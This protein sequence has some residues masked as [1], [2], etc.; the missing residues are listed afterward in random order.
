V[1]W[2]L[3]AGLF[4]AA[5]FLLPA[6]LFGKMHRARDPVQ[7]HK[8]QHSG[9]RRIEHGF[10]WPFLWRRVCAGKFC[11]GNGRRP[12]QGLGRSGVVVRQLACAVR[13]GFEAAR[14]Q[15]LCHKIFDMAV[16]D[17]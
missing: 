9:S 7:V 15:C 1:L 3:A 13:F 16:T 6:D 14:S 2:F 10:G 12:V 4:P 5:F 8:Q 17:R 11:A